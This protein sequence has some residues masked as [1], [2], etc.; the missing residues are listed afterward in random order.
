MSRQV[1]LD[2]E[3][4]GVAV[5]TDD[6]AGGRKWSTE[7]SAPRW[8]R[9]QDPRA[10]AA[11]NGE[12]PVHPDVVTDAGVLLDGSSVGRILQGIVPAKTGLEWREL[13]DQNFRHFC[14]PFEEA[15]LR[16][17]PRMIRSNR[18]TS[19]SQ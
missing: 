19:S 12:A 9:R 16:Q 17:V 8:S 10:A 2:E 5:E 3:I 7:D 6:A 13:S 15:L 18:W 14:E 1:L 11:F 4:H